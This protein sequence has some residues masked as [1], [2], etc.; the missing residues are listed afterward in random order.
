MKLY[1]SSMIK[2]CENAR[3]EDLWTIYGN[4]GCVGGVVEKKDA[5]ISANSG[6]Y[7]VCSEYEEDD[8]GVVSRKGIIRN[9]SAHQ[10]TIS[11]L[12]SKFVLDG[13]EYEVYTQRNTWQNESS[14]GWQPVI[15][16]VSGETLGLRNAYGAAPF[17]AVWNNQTGRGMAFHI[18]TRLPWRFQVKN[19]PAGGEIN[20]LEIEVGINS[21]NFAAKL[22]SGEELELP[23]ILYYEIRNKLDLDCYKL[24]HYMH[25]NFPRRELPVIY[26]T[27]LYTFDKLDFENVASQVERAKELGVEYFVID[28]AWYGQGDMWTCR[29]DW[30]ENKEEAFCGRMAELSELVRGNG[31]KFGFW[32][33]IETAGVDSKM[34]GVHRNYYF[35]YND[36]GNELYFFDF[37]NPEACDYMFR[38]VCSL[39][40]KYQAEFIK[41]DFNQDLK[42]DTYQNAFLDYFKGYTAFVKRVKKTYPDL[43]MENCASGGL[44]M[45]IASGMD[46]D[47]FWL[48]DNQSPYEGMRILKDTLRR[49]PP[50]MIEK[51]ATIQSVCDYNYCIGDNRREKIIATN[52]AGWSNVRGVHQSYLEGF[53]TGGPVGFSCDLNSLSE[54]VVEGLKKFIVQFKKNR[55]FWKNAVC[56][57][58]ADTESVLVLEY[59]D[60]NFER[61]KILVYTNRIRQSKLVI[62]PKLDVAA[63]YC[64]DGKD[65]MSGA[66][67]EAEGMD[68]PLD[69]NY[70]AKQ[71]T[72][73][74]VNI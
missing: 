43:Y 35:T 28:A 27:W 45:A 15:T 26:N 67:I 7:L 74:R 60:M 9:V 58:L 42:P 55:D 24:H 3:A 10:I 20:N 25:K 52:D 51:W 34:L 44:R 38:T 57:I 46:F 36:H 72:M 50:Q 49:M 5:C 70:R 12:M 29:G 21:C 69:G 65:I 18:I 56:R 54:T 1:K 16:A 64:I 4:F 73:E 39:V 62:Y 53:L 13:G 6:E 48:S 59:S 2:I 8:N 63:S 41:F 31:M 66:Q 17:F 33:E 61:A 37:S 47:S 30:Y 23:E 14:G 71:I 40:E 19:V 22:E 68:V 32:L 11:C